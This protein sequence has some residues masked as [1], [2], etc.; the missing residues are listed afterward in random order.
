[1]YCM[2]CNSEALLLN[3]EKKLGDHAILVALTLYTLRRWTYNG[4]GKVKG[5]IIG[6]GESEI[7]CYRI[8][9]SFWSCSPGEAVVAAVGPLSVIVLVDLVD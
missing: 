4:K 8:K 1:M 3:N 9:N 5:H 7:E 6:K 2:E